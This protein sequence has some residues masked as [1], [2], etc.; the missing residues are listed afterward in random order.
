MRRFVRL[1]FF[2][3]VGI[4]W[5]AHS[6]SADLSLIVVDES[7]LPHELSGSR[8]EN[9]SSNY[10]NSA[11]NYDNSGSNYSNS[12]SNYENSASN[13]ANGANGDRR[14]ISSENEFMGYYVF[15]SNGVI[16]FFNASG[17]RIAYKPYNADTKS[18]FTSSGDWCGTLG[19]SNNEL[20][21][22]V[23]ESCYF[24]FLLDN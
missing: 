16:N 12:E 4:F 2:V 13:S 8:Y 20:A 15:S 3:N 11:S 21:L 18:V 9:S 5:L 14:L 7:Q 10:A 24:R 23:S 6:A 22:G 1:V 19:N 17:K